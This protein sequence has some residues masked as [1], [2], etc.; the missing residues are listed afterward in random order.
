MIRVGFSKVKDGARLSHLRKTVLSANLFDPFL[1]S[2]NLKLGFIGDDLASAEE[3]LT[4]PTKISRLEDK[5]LNEGRYVFGY[6]SLDAP[7]KLMIAIE[8]FEVRRNFWGPKYGYLAGVFIYEQKRQG[9]ES[10]YLFSSSLPD[11]NTKLFSL[12][13]QRLEVHTL[14][15]D[16]VKEQLMRL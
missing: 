8:K 16:Q 5:M 9:K 6:Q 12:A 13:V 15:L 14:N 11:L 7:V 4:N 2:N 1:Q 10:Q 3:M